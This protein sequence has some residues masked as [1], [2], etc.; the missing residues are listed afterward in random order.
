MSSIVHWYPRTLRR[1]WGLTQEDVAS[2]LRRG[3]RNRISRI[4]RGLAPPN[5]D[6]ILA[7]GLIFGLSARD[8]W[9]RFHGETLDRLARVSRRL[10]KRLQGD[11]SALATSK[12][13]LLERLWA[14]AEA[15]TKSRTV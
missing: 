9:P 6:E 7:Y 4:E 2:L 14:R 1:E 15:D 11:Q 13:E 3:S 5:A 8:L 10:H 12:R